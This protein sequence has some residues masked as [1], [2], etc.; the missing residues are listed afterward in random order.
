L[1]FVFAFGIYRGSKVDS[2]SG[3]TKQAPKDAVNGLDVAYEEDVTLEVFVASSQFIS[4][5]S[6]F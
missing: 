3:K 6:S 4:K 5:A 1:T 2:E